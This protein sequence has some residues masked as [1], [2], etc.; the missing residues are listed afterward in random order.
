LHDALPSFRIAHPVPLAVQDVV[1]DLHVV[2]DLRRG[3]GGGPGEPRG[4]QPGGE[5]QR[6]AGDL[7]PAP[8][9]DEAPDVPGILLAE[10]RHQLRAGPVQLPAELFQLLGGQFRYGR[11]GCAPFQISISTGPA[12][13]DTQVW[14]RSP[15][16][17]WTTPVRRS[18]TRPERSRTTQP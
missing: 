16:S 14:M 4:R 11:H 12:A 7:Q 2:E 13:A 17:P 18:S 10:A 15:S 8:R 3:E 6:P 5:Q 1:A 9:G